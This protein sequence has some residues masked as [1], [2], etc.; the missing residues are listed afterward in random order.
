MHP[1]RNTKCKRRSSHWLTATET[2]VTPIHKLRRPHLQVSQED[3]NVGSVSSEATV[4]AE[5]TIGPVHASSSSHTQGLEQVHGIDVG[6][7]E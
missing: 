5:S 2:L 6:E 4:S 1:E 7:H 3:I